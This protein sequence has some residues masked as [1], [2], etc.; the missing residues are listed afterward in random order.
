MAKESPAGEEALTNSSDPDI[1]AIAEDL[2]ETNPE[3][4][5][6]LMDGPAEDVGSDY[7][8]CISPAKHF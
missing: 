7:A 5:E 1:E 2:A 6:E 4:E 3:K 8:A